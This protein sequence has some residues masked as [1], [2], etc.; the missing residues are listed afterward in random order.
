[1]SEKGHH[2]TLQNMLNDDSDF[3]RRSIK[4]QQMSNFMDGS[5]KDL[6]QI[7]EDE[8]EQPQSPSK[9]NISKA[10]ILGD[11]RNVINT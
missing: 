2:P 8:E 7:N 9:N 5:N 1:M 11:N 10:S 6:F 4:G 3:T